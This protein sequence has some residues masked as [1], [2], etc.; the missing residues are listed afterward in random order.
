MIETVNPTTGEPLDT[1]EPH[2]EAAV[3]HRL[4]RAWTGWE[5]WRTTGFGERA[6]LLR[7][8]AEGLE[9]RE[10]ELAELMVREMGKPLTAARSEVQKCAW[11]CRYYAD[12]GEEHLQ[13]DVVDVGDDA[14][15]AY[16]RFDPLG[17][18]L[19][20]MPWNFPFWQVFRAAAPSVMAGNTVLL[21]HASNVPGC[22]LEI[23]RLF[24][25][26]G[27]PEGLFASL[28]IS[29]SEAS[30]LI[31]DDRIRAVTLT[32]SV[33]AGRKVAAAAGEHLKPSVL[34]LG[35]SDAFIVLEDA[36]LERAAELG[37]KSRLI[38]NGQSCIAAKRFIVHEAVA[39]EYVER[40]TAAVEAMT[41]G[42]PME[43]STDIGPLAREDLRDDLHDQVTRS[44]AEGARV[45]LGGE[46]LDRPGY[47]YAPTILDGVGPEMAAGGEET[48]GPAAAVL[49][50]ADEESA[51]AVANSS[52]F[53][54]GTSVWTED[55]E[56][57]ERVAARIEA[58]CLMINQLVKSDPRV[59]F[60]GVKD[61]GY[62]RELGAYGIKEFVNTKT[63][64]VE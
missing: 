17:P 27:A 61:S 6:D 16:V 4:A 59:P 50:V 40:L 24:T 51:I 19:A 56:R 42:D 64:W 43:E 3:T 57:G 5:S 46:P 60:G 10:Q 8:V 15:T 54:L 35:G 32:G 30:E 2:D 53:G 11:V 37:A 33:P 39:D 38:N 58:G 55:R 20:I 14:R 23:E 52:D 26:A 13:H 34:E 22:A 12:H 44:V 28:L 29:G 63:V 48:F 7:N 21:K 36:D 41:V 18:L 45:V 62:G 47:F 49:R 31:A 1:Y 9:K 25:D